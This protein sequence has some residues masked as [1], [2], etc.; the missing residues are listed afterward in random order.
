M[1]I[2]S[3]IASFVLV[4]IASGCGLIPEQ[5]SCDRR[6]ALPECEDLLSNRNNHFRQ[7]FENI[8]SLSQGTWSDGL[9]DH[10]GALGGC[11]CEGCEN[12]ETITWFFT[13]ARDGTLN[14]EDDV[15]AACEE[16]SLEFVA[17]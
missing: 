5:G 2:F 8:C 9:C 16:S 12:G 6:P 14:S 10:T 7:T 17:P 11:R 15:R 3:L 4:I 1:K 13:G